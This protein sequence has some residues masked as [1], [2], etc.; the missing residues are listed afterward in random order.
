[1]AK[2]NAKILIIISTFSSFYILLIGLFI[3]I[4][5]VYFFTGPMLSLE[6]S[7]VNF[8]LTDLSK[9][10]TK[11]FK[12]TNNSQVEAI[13]QVLRILVMNWSIDW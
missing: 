9:E 2:L 8:G 6:V 11:S 10:V 12:I 4:V 5:I 3:D 13:Y 1:M 7:S